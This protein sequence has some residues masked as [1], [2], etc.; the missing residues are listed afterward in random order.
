MS[1]Q[2]FLDQLRLGLSGFPQKEIEERISFY[3]EMIDDYMEEG[4]SLQE[5]LENV[6]SVDEIV[7]Q[8]VK[9]LS[10]TKLVVE[11][12][13]PKKKLVAWQ[14]ILIIV[15]FPLCFSLLIAV[16]AVALSLYLV[17]CSLVVSLWSVQ[18]A[19]WVTSLCSFVAGGINLFLGN[20][21]NAVA[22]VGIGFLSAG[23]SVFTFLGCL[24]V[25]KRIW[26]L[27]QNTLVS[28]KSLFM[29]RG[30]GK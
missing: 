17:I 22:F 3:D 26:R 29:R 11:K 6:G 5:A 20:S 14:K 28:V 15:G 4:S 30:T 25:T 10:L 19:L 27:T 8:A 7:A 13:K 23:L 12:I 21:L 16:L 9:E 1:K 2:V 18:V 24:F